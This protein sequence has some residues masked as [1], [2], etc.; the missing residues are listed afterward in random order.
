MNKKDQYKNYL[1]QMISDFVKEGNLSRKDY[2]TKSS[3]LEYLI[4]NEH[5]L[6]MFGIKIIHDNTTNTFGD[7]TGLDIENNL[8][9]K[10]LL[11]N[12]GEW[13]KYKRNGINPWVAIQ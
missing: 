10:S 8:G 1:H 12:D 3:F 4:E 13:I 9:T 7:L 11:F 2:P 5:M 6:N